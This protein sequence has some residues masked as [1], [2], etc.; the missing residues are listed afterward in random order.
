MLIDGVLPQDTMIMKHWPFSYF[1]DPLQMS[2]LSWFKSY[3]FRTLKSKTICRRRQ[4]LTLFIPCDTGLKLDQSLSFKAWFCLPLLSLPVTIFKLAE[5]EH[6]LFGRFYG[7]Q[8]IN[9]PCRYVILEDTY[10]TRSAEITSSFIRKQ[11][12]LLHL[13]MTMPRFNV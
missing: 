8:L 12:L 13:H 9:H 3:G 11:R 1:W 2:S 6:D 7:L 5:L 4:M 10:V